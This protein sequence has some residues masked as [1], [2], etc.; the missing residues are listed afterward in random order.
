M[1]GAIKFSVALPIT[2]LTGWLSG[3]FGGFNKWGRLAAAGGA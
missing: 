2:A 3:V 1:T